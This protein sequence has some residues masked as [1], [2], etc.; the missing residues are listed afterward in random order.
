MQWKTGDWQRK[1][2]EK[3]PAESQE[4]KKEKMKKMMMMMKN[5]N[6]MNHLKGERK[7]Q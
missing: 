7:M 4:R 3:Q 2:R 6:M 5:K 1:G